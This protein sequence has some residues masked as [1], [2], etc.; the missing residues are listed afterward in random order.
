MTTFG[1][2]FILGDSYSTFEGFIPQGYDA[3]YINEGREQ[4]DVNDVG[5]TWWYQLMNDTASNLVRNCS[6]SGTT[7]CHTGYGGADRSDNSFAARVDKLIDS[8][9]FKEKTI[10]TFFVFGGTND[11]WAD[12]PVGELKYSAWKKEDLYQVLPAFCYLLNRLHEILPETRIVCIINTE[13]KPEITEGFKTACQNYKTEILELRNIDKMNGH[14]TILGMK[15]IK[16]QVAEI[17]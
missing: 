13:L 3:Y 2:V 15:Q 17:V 8:G 12:S 16:E 1:N 14:P 4:T 6:W 10:D 7:V 9:Y 5:Q 11:S